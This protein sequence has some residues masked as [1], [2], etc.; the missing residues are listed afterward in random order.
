M[1]SRFWILSNEDSKAAFFRKAYL[2]K[3][4]GEWSYSRSSGWT[5]ESVKEEPKIDNSVVSETTEVDNA[6]EED[7]SVFKTL[8]RKRRKKT[9]DE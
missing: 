1:S 9:K 6:T 4:G 8:K 5:W 7:I 2:E 3:N